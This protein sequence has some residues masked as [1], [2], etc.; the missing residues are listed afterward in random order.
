MQWIQVATIITSI[1][2]FGWYFLVRIEK[3]V[4]RIEKKGDA[5]ERR[6]DGHAARIDQLYTMFVDLLK[7]RK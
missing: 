3:D 6:M 7:E 5:F 1:I 4:D 2:G